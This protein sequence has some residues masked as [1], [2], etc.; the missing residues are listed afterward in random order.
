M[1]APSNRLAFTLIELLVV[2]AIIAILIALLVPAVQKVREAAARTQCLNNL[3]QI[4][5]AVHGY[6]DANR[7]LPSAGDYAIGMTSKSW[8]VSARLLPFVEQ[9]ALHK[10]INF[11]LTYDNVANLPA[12]QFRVPLQ[13]CPSDPND[14]PRPDGAVTHYPISY[15]A[16][17]GTWLIFNPSTQQGG[18]G[19]FLIN[20]QVRL[21]GITDGTSNTLAFAEVKMYTPYLRDGGNPSAAGTAPPATPAAI[22]GFGGSFKADSGHT[23]WVDA[24]VH[25]TGFTTTFAPN[26]PVPFVNGGV[27]YD[28]DF[29][30]SREGQTTTAIT[31]AAVTSRSYHSG[32]VNVLLMDGTARSIS[33]TVA[34]TVWRALGTRMGNEVV[35]DF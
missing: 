31:Y 18:D 33:S 14:R 4:G 20:R 22:S 6:H 30:S 12:A 11:S 15:G 29:N 7:G 24:R 35:G 17:F 23:E 3:K 21:V 28:V 19:A 25:Q 2:I 5:L 9:D 13:I 34:L 26:T 8:S 32:I 1:R 16:N 10:L 27:T